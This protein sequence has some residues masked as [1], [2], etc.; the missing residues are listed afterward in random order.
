MCARNELKCHQASMLTE[1]E[2]EREREK[3]EERSARRTPGCQ[4]HPRLCLTKLKEA[5]ND[6]KYDQRRGQPRNARVFLF[7]FFFPPS[8]SLSLSLSLSVPGSLFISRARNSYGT[9]GAVDY[10][11][12]LRR[13]NSEI[14]TRAVVRSLNS[15][16]TR[17]IMVI[18]SI[19]RSHT[20]IF[21]CIPDNGDREWER[22]GARWP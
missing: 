11:A 2:R 15:A 9:V 20:Y 18:L 12:K 17:E 6:N 19:C 4:I 10:S 16:W 1:R 7:L 22:P 13:I 8:L 5:A 3:E 14:P 21:G